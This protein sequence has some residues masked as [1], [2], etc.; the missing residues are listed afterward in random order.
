MKICR[1]KTS[2]S[3]IGPSENAPWRVRT[4]NKVFKFENRENN[5]YTRNLVLPYTCR[6]LRKGESDY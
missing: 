4:V 1:G 2:L 6:E 5:G 3:Y